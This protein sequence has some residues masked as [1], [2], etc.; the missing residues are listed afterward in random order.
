MKHKIKQNN[1]KIQELKG[2]H[3]KEL[4]D[5][6]DKH[7]IEVQRLQ[8]EIQRRQASTSHPAS[9]STPKAE[10]DTSSQLH[11]CEDTVAR[12]LDVNP[13]GGTVLSADDPAQKEAE[14]PRPLSLAPPSAPF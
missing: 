3:E 14:D 13:I 7:A 1:G 2:R 6:N 8:D 9:P 5:V 12:Q 11:Q 10:A 4:Q